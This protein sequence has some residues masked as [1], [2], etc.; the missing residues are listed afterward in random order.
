MDLNVYKGSRID[1]LPSVFRLPAL[2][3]RNVVQLAR[4]VLRPDADAL[5][6]Y[7]HRLDGIA[8]IHN[9][10]FMETPRFQCA[11]ARAVKA[12]GWDY[13]IPFRVHQ[14]LW[15]SRQ[16]QKV[17]GDFVELG[18]GRGFIMSAVM[19][20]FDG[21]ILSGR[22]LHLFD[23]FK[24][25]HLDSGGVQ[26]SEKGRCPAY[27][28]S[29]E[30]TRENFLEWPGVVIHEGDVIESLQ[31]VELRPAFLHIDL[32]NAPPEIFGLRS[33]WP[34]IPPGGVVLL[35]DYGYRGYEKQGEAM[36]LLAQELGFDILTVPTGQGIIIK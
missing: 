36:D 33:L 2:V 29:V 26:R 18:T 9:T 28:I 22:T 1:R 23:T 34:N 14:A 3:A 10:K 11:Y 6:N 20:D 32:N 30:K 27:S 15:C 7:P 16:A 24:S 4:N 25:F 35:D 17:S 8:T 13:G 31:K 12:A 21:W 5:A 19:A